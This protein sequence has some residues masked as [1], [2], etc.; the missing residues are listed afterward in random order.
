MITFPQTGTTKVTAGLP[1][2]LPDLRL[3]AAFGP[4]DA[5]GQSLTKHNVYMAQKCHS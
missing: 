4:M 2:N 5:A 1:W 3:S